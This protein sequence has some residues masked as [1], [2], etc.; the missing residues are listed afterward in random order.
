M[1]KRM[2][3]FMAGLL[4]V[5]L[6]I[7]PAH[8]VG[9]ED[10]QVGVTV[11]FGFYHAV[12]SGRCVPV[13]ITVEKRGEFGEGVLELKVPVNSQEQYIYE[14]DILLKQHGTQKI[15]FYIPVY[16]DTKYL[17]I[18]VYDKDGNCVF[19]RK[20]TMI[21]QDDY[22]EIFTG[23]LDRM[24]NDESRLNNLIVDD[25]SDISIKEFHIT[26]DNFPEHILDL[27]LLDM[28]IVNPSAEKILTKSKKKILEQWVDQGGLCIYN[29]SSKDGYQALGNGSICYYSENLFEQDEEALKE[30]FREII[31]KERMSKIQ[32][33]MMMRTDSDY[34]EI[35][36]LVSVSNQG[37]AAPLYL[38][39]GL[40]ILYLITVCPLVFYLLRIRKKS[41]YYS[42]IVI[43]GACLFSLVI[44][45]AGSRTRVY[46]S[47]V[48]YCKIIHLN[49]DQIYED[50]YLGIRSP[51]NKENEIT[52]DPSYQVF[53]VQNGYN[54][55]NIYGDY[56]SLMG[57]D[58]ER[59]QPDDYDLKMK[60]ESACSRIEI[61]NNK[62]FDV[63]LFHLKKGEVNRENKSLDARLHIFDN[64]VTGQVTNQTG[65]D[66][67]DVFIAGFSQFYYIGQIKAGETVELN[68]EP[69]TNYS[70]QYFQ[71][72]SGL[73][74]KKHEKAAAYHLS[75]CFAEPVNRFKIAGFTGDDGKF[76]GENSFYV[77][78]TALIS[79]NC[80]VDFTEGD[81]IYYPVLL[82]RPAVIS[83]NYRFK[84]FMMES[85]YCV[86]NYE[87]GRE[88]Q[89][90]Y[91]TFYENNCEAQGIA[92]RK[93]FSG[94]AYF[95]NW[96][97]GIYE[98][99]SLPGRFDRKA[100]EPYLNESN[101]IQVKYVDNAY[102]DNVYSIGIPYLT[103]TGR[104][105][106]AGSKGTDKTI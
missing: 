9:G 11:D 86:V 31:D 90:D 94:T 88:L 12:K 34:W 76:L 89:I 46:Q 75:T 72:V 57:V 105:Q 6:C 62:A 41:A 103:V 92:Y 97:T 50:T 56:F 54:S 65:K 28:I 1:S 74:N 95:M 24:E 84:S 99:V 87:L 70:V 60:V 32:N 2:I 55:Y 5:L 78:G 17:K 80:Q 36:D 40:L 69:L 22:G 38:Y 25:N 7:L 100:L 104:K 33:E 53:P 3:S 98:E 67:E 58:S 16:A 93:S 102:G 63:S 13:H 37:S 85:G 27:D 20:E 39:M 15:D 47:I 18:N 66:L 91:I 106:D 42:Y 64:E 10:S 59:S 8:A 35:N 14:H 96:Q 4:L 48:N 52:V 81:Q 44:L 101:Q 61:K 19:T 26:T 77:N 21:L 73:F 68:Q 82:E 43:G 45:A 23:I 30:I 83:G 29:E 51:N 79:Q 49:P 71:T